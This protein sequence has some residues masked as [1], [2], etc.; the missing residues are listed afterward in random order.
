MTIT[1]IPNIYAPT[2]GDPVTIVENLE[3]NDAN[4]PYIPYENRVEFAGRNGYWD[5]N[6]DI[7]NIFVRWK[8]GICESLEG[9]TNHDCK[10]NLFDLAIMANDWLV[11]CNFNPDNPACMA[12]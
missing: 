2:P 7:D 10:V 6:A 5:I 9:D 8:P 3:I 12:E 11:D 4:H 1:L